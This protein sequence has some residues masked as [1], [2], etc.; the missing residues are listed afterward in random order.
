MSVMSAKDV[1]HSNIESYTS[2]DL[3]SLLGSG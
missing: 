1:I 2:A 3:C